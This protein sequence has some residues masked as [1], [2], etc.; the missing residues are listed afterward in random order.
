MVI[1]IMG[2]TGA[3]KTRLSV[4]LATRISAEII[5]ADKMQV[6]KG[7]DIVTNK[8]TEPERKNVSHHLLGEVDPESDF[9]ARDFYYSAL[10]S[11]ERIVMAGRVPIVVGGSNSFIEA[12]VEDPFFKSQYEYCFLWLDVCLPI[13]YKFVSKRVDHMVNA[14]LVDEVEK[15]FDPTADYSKG[16]RRAIGVPEMDMYFRTAGMKMDVTSR[17]T[18]LQNAIREIKENTFKLV[19]CQLRKIQRLRNELGWAMHKI[20]ATIVFEKC[21]EEAN[22]AWEKEVLQPSLD[23]VT[24]FLKMK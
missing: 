6:Y 20:D 22:F 16:I 12:L 8:I 11:I 15:I 9:T 24:N 1:F 13:L 18:L 3:G 10:S 19:C 23:I 5:N 17:E 4:D 21:G 7:L 14:G 2:A